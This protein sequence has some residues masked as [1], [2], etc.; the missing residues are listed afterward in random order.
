MALGHP[1]ARFP[2]TFL[3]GLPCTESLGMCSKQ[4]EVAPLVTDPPRAILHPFVKYTSLPTPNC[5]SLIWG[6]KEA[7]GQ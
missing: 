7:T 3:I 1:W 4:D 6:I 5:T 2:L